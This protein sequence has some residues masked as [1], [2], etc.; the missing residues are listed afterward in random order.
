MERGLDKGMS[1]LP[2]WNQGDFPWS[3]FP[4][5]YLFP[6]SHRPRSPNGHTATELVGRT[7]T[8]PHGSGRW[9][10]RA[11]PSDGALARGRGTLF[12]LEHFRGCAGEETAA[13]MHHGNFSKAR[14]ASQPA[15]LV[16]IK[17]NLNSQGRW[18]KG[19]DKKDRRASE[20]PTQPTE[21]LRAQ[22]C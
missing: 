18:R 5:D 3:F 8:N 19:L 9:R 7:E 6:V 12:C 17:V 2:T 14:S 21:K 15:K 1:V 20:K 22:G 4:K 16:L 13:G 11:V 10:K